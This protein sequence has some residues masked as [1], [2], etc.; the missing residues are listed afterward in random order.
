MKKIL[1][2]AT[3]S[4]LVVLAGCSPYSSVQVKTQHRISPSTTVSLYFS[5][6]DRSI[7]RNY[8]VNYY[9]FKRVP[10]G[11]YKRRGRPFQRHQPLPP[12]MHYQPIPYELNRRL[13]PLP[14]GYIRIRIGEDIAIMNTRTRV[15]LDTMWFLD[16]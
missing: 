4:S 15:I 1:L 2:L 3:L 14:Q 16:K 9:G 7:I 12:N 13:P 6:S 11:H 10:P 5:D 8:Y